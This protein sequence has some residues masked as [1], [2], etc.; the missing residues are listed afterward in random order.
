[1]LTTFLGRFIC[2]GYCA[3]LALLLA[4]C[5]S[6]RSSNNPPPA[7]IGSAPR[8]EKSAAAQAKAGNAIAQ[9]EAVKEKF[10]PIAVNGK[11]FEGWPKPKLA[12]VI[13]GR[14]D[15]YLEPCG[16]AGLENQKGGLS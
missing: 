16:C 13:S 9:D 15:G 5:D 4:G 6:A 10:D 2:F 7:A 8:A 12:L 11:F 14:Q 3:A 1:M